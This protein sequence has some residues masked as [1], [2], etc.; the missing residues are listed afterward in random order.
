MK[1]RSLNYFLV[2]IGIAFTAAIPFLFKDKTESINQTLN[3]SATIVSSL[4]AIVTLWIAF[5]LFN[6]YG[7]DSSLLEKSSSKVFD[8]LEQIKAIR[9]SFGSQKF[10][11][12]VGMSDPFKYNSHIEVHYK[13][14]LVFSEMYFNSLQRVFEINSSPFMP[15]A[16]AEKVDRLQFILM[17]FDVP[18]SIIDDY[19]KVLVMGHKETPETKF[20]RFNGEDLTVFEF[21]NILED[22]KVATEEWVKDNSAIPV[23][24]N[25]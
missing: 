9:F 13:E 14:K 6:K 23:K 15:T 19:L 17:S 12:N 4:A 3:L 8:L 25:L 5:L 7:V 21:L 22:I 24:L 10:W 20:G 2:L 16:I 18:D 1:Q 11:F